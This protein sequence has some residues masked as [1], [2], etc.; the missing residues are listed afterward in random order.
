MKKGQADLPPEFAELTRRNYLFEALGEAFRADEYADR[1]KQVAVRFFLQKCGKQVA[2][3]TIQITEL[4]LEKVADMERERLEA[5][6][7]IADHIA[8]HLIIGAGERRATSQ[9]VRRKLRLGELMQSLSYM[10]RKLSEIRKPLSWDKV[11]KALNIESEDDRTASDYWLVQELILIRLYERLANS[12]ALAELP[13]P[14]APE[15]SPADVPA[16]QIN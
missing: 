4:F 8:D 2:P 6:R 5:I 11:L 1:A 7:E 12:P 13:E 10:Q 3:G 15:P 14:E 9:L 16:E